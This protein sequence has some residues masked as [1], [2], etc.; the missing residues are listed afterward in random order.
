LDFEFLLY[1]EGVVI[2]KLAVARQKII[3]VKR[4]KDTI[5]GACM[6]SKIIEELQKN[7][8]VTRLVKSELL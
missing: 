3:W 5:E 4:G 7:P 1:K 2:K 6:P 8:K